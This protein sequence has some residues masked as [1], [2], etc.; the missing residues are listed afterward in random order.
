MAASAE[1]RTAPLD[2][3]RD[4]VRQTPPAPAA[5]DAYL[6]KVHRHA[7]RVTDAD[8]E[9]LKDAG[10]TE[11]EIFE[12]TVAAA[13]AEGLRRLDAAERAIG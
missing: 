1:T 9:A 3:L 5:M 8:V 7:Y 6:D 11:D 2:D 10:V 13:I 12:Q 4:V